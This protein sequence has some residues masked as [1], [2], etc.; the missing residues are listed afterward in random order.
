MNRHCEKISSQY[1]A[2]SLSKLLC[3]IAAAFLAGCAGEKQS[4][5]YETFKLALTSPDT[6]IDQ[7][8]L[9]PKYR[10]LKVDANGQPALLVLGYI[11]TKKNDAQ[12]VWYSA[13]REVVEIKGGRLVNTEGLG[14]NWTQVQLIDPP[15]LAD[16]FNISNTSSN[17]RNPKFRFSRMRTVMPGYHVN[18]RET[19]VLEALTEIPSG[20]PKVLQNPESNRNIAWVQETVLIPPNNQNPSI[21]PLRAIYAIDINTKEVV[22]GKQYLSPTFYVS[23][24]S[25]PYPKQTAP[26]K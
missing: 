6:I 4:P 1:L 22:F 9:N 20:I 11:D 23:W 21:K 12:E 24:L 19:V 17:K 25:W 3:L 8:P 18:I 5:I 16:A 15:P 2:T 13:F 26:L 7:T 10:Y 14:I